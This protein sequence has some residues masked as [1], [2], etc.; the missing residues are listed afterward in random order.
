VELFREK[1]VILLLRLHD[2]TARGNLT[3]YLIYIRLYSK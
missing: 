2:L 1:N 3:I